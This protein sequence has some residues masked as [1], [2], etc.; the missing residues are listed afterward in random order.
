MLLHRVPKLAHDINFQCNMTLFSSGLGQTKPGIIG[1]ADYSSW[2]IKSDASLPANQLSSLLAA[3]SPLTCS[4]P[5]SSLSISPGVK[6]KWWWSLDAD[7]DA[8]RSLAAEQLWWVEGMAW[9]VCVCACVVEE[10]RGGLAGVRPCRSNSCLIKCRA[11]LWVVA[12]ALALVTSSPDI[13]CPAGLRSLYLA[14]SHFQ[15]EV[16]DPF[17]SFTPH[18]HM[19]LFVFSTLSSVTVRSKGAPL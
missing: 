19:R 5:P 7:V 2:F 8:V 13:I 18:L 16:A 1:A 12:V 10:C 6:V 9:W 17:L 11:C 15:S 14:L 3:W 4:L